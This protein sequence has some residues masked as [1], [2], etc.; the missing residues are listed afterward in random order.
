MGVKAGEYTVFSRAFK[1][2]NNEI[3][4]GIVN[5]SG[6]K[7]T[8]TTHIQR[9][10][11]LDV[12]EVEQSVKFFIDVRLSWTDPTIRWDPALDTQKTSSIKVPEDTVWSPDITIFSAVSKTFPIPSSRRV[13]RVNSD[14]GVVKSTAQI[15]LN[16][17]PLNV[18]KFPFDSQE[19]LFRIGPWA[20][21]N[22]E[23]ALRPFLAPKLNISDEEY[24]RGNSE[25]KIVSIE[26]EAYADDSYGKGQVY[27]E[28]HYTI[29]LKRAWPHYFW[30]LI[31]PTF[32]CAT[33]CI[34]GLFMPSES[35]GYR[36]EKVSL[37]VMTLVSMSMVLETFSATMPKSSTL[38]LLG[39]Y[40]LAEELVCACATLVTVT[41]SLLHERATTR[42]WMVP[43]GLA[44][45][46]LWHSY[47][48][49][50][51]TRATSIQPMKGGSV[52]SP[53]LSRVSSYLR[54]LE[55]D[56]ALAAQWMRIFDRL[57]IIGMTIFQVINI[58]INL[59]I[60][61]GRS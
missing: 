4:P 33:L 9:L 48:T 15:I 32:I 30:V 26:V 27:D 40:V 55:S 11:L 59:A 52:L 18:N 35:S 13:V 24:F 14:G 38:P 58:I 45:M 53:H 51:R 1:A 10:Q 12:E 8:V 19:C 6:N 56:D 3:M 57:D 37:G 21:D 39:I 5:A 25:W 42:R 7:I 28:V 23:V 16:P 43:K 47:D 31:L 54:E 36:F 2:Y 20:Y 44:K 22:S 60:L 49:H 61:V 17:C 46:L 50:I 41:L 34:F 29:K